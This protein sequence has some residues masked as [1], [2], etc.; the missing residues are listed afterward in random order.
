M[1]MFAG[2]DVGFKWTAVCVLDERGEIVWRGIVDTHPETL[3][4]ALRRWRDVLA[5]VGLESGSMSPWLARALS[6]L[7]FP[8]VCMDARRAAVAI[9]S[10][11]VKSDKADA[12]ALAEM[13]R[14]GWYSAVPRR[15]SA[16]RPRSP[17][18]VPPSSSPLYERGNAVG[19]LDDVLPDARRDQLVADDA[20]DHGAD[21]AP[22]QPIDGEG[23]HASSQS[24]N[25]LSGLIFCRFE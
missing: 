7:G 12:Y 17:P 18:P 10:R 23:G 25:N 21:F 13:L 4:A 2:L 14:T 11:R 8:V 22:R 20:V 1:R 19:A 15:C 16:L 5:K 9:Q 3:A 6:A 24:N